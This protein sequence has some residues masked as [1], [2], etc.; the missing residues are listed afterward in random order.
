M[1]ATTSAAPD[2]AAPA[3]GQSE[4]PASARLVS[5]DVFRGMTIAGM[6]L[7]NNPGTWE[8]VYPEL[9]HADWH[10]WTYT[11]TVFPF[12]LWIVGVAL[13]LSFARRRDRGEDRR[14]LLAH[15]ARRAAL[16]FLVGIL[17]NGF[18]YYA[19][20]RIRIP[21][22]LQ[23]IAI[24]Y[25]I[26]ATIFLYSRIRGQAIALLVCLASY[27]MLMTLVP[28]PG[29]GPGHL[30]KGQNFSA[31]VDQLLL[32]GHMWSSTKTWDP[33]GT[34]STLP[35]IATTLF[36]VL[37]GHLLRIVRDPATRAAWILSS[38]AVLTFVG[39]VMAWWMPINKSIWTSSYAV[40]MAG[41]AAL[42]FGLCYWFL[43]ANA[44]KGW[45]SRPFAIYG[46]NAIAVY[47][48][49]GVVARLLGIIKIDGNPLKQLIFNSAFL[50]LGS[51]IN[52][53]LFYGLANV[54]FFFLVAYALY[55]R[56]WFLRF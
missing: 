39:S 7:V 25:L 1:H 9:R 11:D 41:L 49:A 45:W 14:R 15:T 17:L 28:V 10:G 34:V 35:A 42:M 40:F 5:L 47:I 21:G 56:G 12:F 18:P 55:R 30:E 48:A 22:V 24:C 13:T 36:G 27:W 50:P 38:G 43:D 6:M 33:E 3:R 2:S 29:L 54:L 52:A 19:L 8:A 4:T 37:T 20:D 16:I 23:R 51:P 53:S 46:M 32:S 44:W 31:W 26:A